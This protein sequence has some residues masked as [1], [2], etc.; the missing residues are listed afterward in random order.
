MGLPH[1]QCHF[2]VFLLQNGLKP[3]YL[4]SFKDGR[5][6]TD[7]EVAGRYKFY[8]SLENSNCNDYVTEKL[9]RAY[10]VGAVPILDGPKDY[11]RFLAT[12]HSYLRL[13][14][15]ATPEQL[16]LRIQQLDQDDTAYM[17]YLDYK[18]SSA[19][20]ESLLSPKL[21]ET[22]DVPQGTWGPDADGARCG[23]CELAHDMAEGS[24]Q[25]NPNKFV[26]PDPT[27]AFKKWVFISWVAEYYRLAIVLAVLGIFAGATVLIA[28]RKSRRARRCFQALKY[29]LTPSS[30]RD[31]KVTDAS[32]RTDDYQL[33]E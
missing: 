27:C 16:A 18:Q 33:L 26:G 2:F 3:S 12:N 21:L 31:K 32:F 30:W 29:N 1:S 9:E 8:L 5:D 14:D 7:R 17:R 19:P 13:D 20:I 25:Y 4:F 10:T 6:F 11:S 28:C 23:V 22:F 15:F 24:Y